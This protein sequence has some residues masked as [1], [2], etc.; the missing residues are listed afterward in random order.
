MGG[1][2]HK[3]VVVI[4]DCE[5]GESKERWNFDI[6]TDKEAAATYVHNGNAFLYLILSLSTLQR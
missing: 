4:A 6:Q 5:T 1:N 3:L 2:V